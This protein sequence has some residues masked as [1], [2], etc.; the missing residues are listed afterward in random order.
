MS[1]IL[2]EFLRQGNFVRVSAIEP[3]TRLEAV[4]IVPASL[5]ENQMKIQALNKLKY[6][7]QKVDRK[8]VV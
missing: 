6:L 3:K 2:F 8:S 5:D 1:E 4:V 7:L